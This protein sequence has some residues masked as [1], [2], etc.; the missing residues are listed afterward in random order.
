MITSLDDRLNAF[1]DA[2]RARGLPVSLSERLDAMRAVEGM[3]L[4]ALRTALSA[5]LVKNSEHLPTFDQMYDLYFRTPGAPEPVE[6]DEPFDELVNAV[7]Q[8]RCARV[9]P[10][11]GR[12]GGRAV[13][14]VRAR[15][16]GG[17]GLVR[18]A[19][20]ERHGAAGCGRRTG[21]EA[22]AGG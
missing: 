16:V 21:P 17:R 9:V 2:L 11:A 10:P 4:T 3:E 8:R 12:T 18:A 13:L 6:T 20:H 1:V 15:T 19:G 22:A 5:T 14:P 7:L